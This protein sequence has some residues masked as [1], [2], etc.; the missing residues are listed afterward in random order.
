MW[1]GKKLKTE[2][3]LTNWGRAGYHNSCH[4]I[5]C[6]HLKINYTPREDSQNTDNPIFREQ[7]WGKKK[8]LHV[9]MSMYLCTILLSVEKNLV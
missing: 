4:E 7:Y 6:N 3:L 8:N 5:L 2:Y 1:S 9:Y